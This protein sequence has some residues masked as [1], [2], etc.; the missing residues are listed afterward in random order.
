MT[1]N[2]LIGKISCQLIS[3]KQAADLKLQGEVYLMVIPKAYLQRHGI[4]AEKFTFCA[5]EDEDNEI[6]FSDT[7]TL[8]N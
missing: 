1:H 5:Y 7:P 6:Y 3:E 2:K 8:E 4:T